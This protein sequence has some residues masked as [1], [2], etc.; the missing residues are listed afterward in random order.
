MFYLAQVLN[1]AMNVVGLIDCIRLNVGPAFPH[2]YWTGYG[3]Q[4]A[5]LILCTCMCFLGSATFSKAS[6]GL[7]AILSLAIVSIPISSIFKTPFYDEKLGINFTGLNLNTL[8]NNFLPH[9]NASE[10]KGIT[11]FRELFG[12]LFP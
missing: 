11:T 9:A 2:G 6:N 8:A 5:V 3:L 12:I 7:L 10:Y 1:T 4:T